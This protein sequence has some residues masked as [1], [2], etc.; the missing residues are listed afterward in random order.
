MLEVSGSKFGIV[1]RTKE[2]LEVS[3]PCLSNLEDRK[4]D[5]S[6]ES[7][8]SSKES[9]PFCITDGICIKDGLGGNAGGSLPQ[10]GR[11]PAQFW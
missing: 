10:D 2:V 1:G 7:L 4:L 6:A 11:L 3:L 8:L 5:S 9:P